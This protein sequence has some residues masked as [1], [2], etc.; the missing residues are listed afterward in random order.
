MLNVTVKKALMARLNVGIYLS[1]T[2]TRCETVQFREFSLSDL[3]A[4][5]NTSRTDAIC[6]SI[7]SGRVDQALGR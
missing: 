7:V 4:V 5:E 3:A 1:A 2:Q 6:H